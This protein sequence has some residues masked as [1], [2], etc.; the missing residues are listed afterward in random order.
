MCF[1]DDINK[2]IKVT[3]CSDLPINDNGI[4]SSDYSF[5]YNVTEMVNSAA[6][7]S[8]MFAAEG[9]SVSM[10]CDDGNHDRYAPTKHNLICQRRSVLDVI[11]K[12]ADFASRNDQ[13]NFS[14]NQIADTAPL[15]I[16]KKQN[17]TR[18][19][20]VVENN[21]DMLQ[22][23]S[24]S[25]LRLAMRFWA[26]YVVPDNTELGLVL[27]TANPGKSFKIVSV[28]NGNVDRFGSTNRDNFYS[29]LPYTP[30]DSTQ[31]GCLHCALKIAMDMLTDRTS[32]HG[33][34]N[35]VVVV[36]APGMTLT[37]QIKNIAD[38]LKR[39]NIRAATINYPDIV[40]PNTLRYLAE[41]TNG[42]DYTIFE[43]KLNV[44]TT[45]LT[46]Y[47][48]LHNIL[49]NLVQKF[50][51]GR[52]ADLPMEVSSNFSLLNFPLSKFFFFNYCRFIVEKSPTKPVDLL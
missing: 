17:L 1:F 30:S 20:F 5:P 12:H 10:F 26:N 31:P 3:G 46:T 29:A 35:N 27:S 11:L 13:N 23:E 15:I 52:Q 4:C 24:W 2:K 36:I 32:T 25:Y 18:Y 49:Y 28:K 42:V 44:D 6:R 16:Y 50:Y 37:D 22:R 51:S 39:N 47:F 41:E 48:E 33:P 43:K 8:I 19:V 38:D 9:P 21:K 45:M 14:N 34:A 40:R 7:S